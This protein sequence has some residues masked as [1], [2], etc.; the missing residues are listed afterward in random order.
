MDEPVSSHSDGELDKG[1][2]WMAHWDPLNNLS[3]LRVGH[4]HAVSPEMPQEVPS[5]TYEKFLSKKWTLNWLK[6]L[7][8]SAT[9]LTGTKK[10]REQLKCHHKARKW[11]TYRTSDQ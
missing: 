10:I 5:T 4:P 8:L 2:P 7:E 3:S 1:E 11:G 6:L 9:S